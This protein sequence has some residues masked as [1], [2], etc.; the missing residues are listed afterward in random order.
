MESERR[1]RVAEEERIAGWKRG[2]DVV[3]LVRVVPFLPAPP[4][5]VDFI[6]RAVP[7]RKALSMGQRAGSVLVALRVDYEPCGRQRT[8]L[9]GTAGPVSSEAH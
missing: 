7:L 3:V 4:R 2:N 1:G 9:R 5:L 6:P 8:V